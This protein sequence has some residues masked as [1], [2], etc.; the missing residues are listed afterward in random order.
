[1][2]RKLKRQKGDLLH[3]ATEPRRGDAGDDL[4][5]EKSADTQEDAPRPLLYVQRHRRKEKTPKLNDENLE[6]VTIQ[7]RGDIDL[8]TVTWETK[9][10]NQMT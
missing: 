3:G 7:I 8:Q 4:L 1:M 5:P 10:A 9:V 6:K 2:S